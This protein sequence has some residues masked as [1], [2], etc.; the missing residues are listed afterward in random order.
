[1][2]WNDD[3]LNT[4]TWIQHSIG[5]T[6]HAYQFIVVAKSRPSVFKCSLWG[7]VR[8]DIDDISRLWWSN[9]SHLATLGTRCDISRL[10]WSSISHL[11]SNTWNEVYHHDYQQLPTRGMKLRDVI[12]TVW[13]YTAI[14]TGTLEGSVLKC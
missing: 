1:M 4:E 7:G 13:T 6:F 8:V 2:H 10:W 14:T 5:Y 9:I 3:H 12:R 11:A